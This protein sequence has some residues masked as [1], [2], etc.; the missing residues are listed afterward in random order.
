MGGLLRD[1]QEW[2]IQK[3][4]E[5]VLPA[6]Q[7]MVVVA[8]IPFRCRAP[9]A[10]DASRF[11]LGTIPPVTPPA[12]ARLVARRTPA[13]AGRP[14]RAPSVA[15]PCFVLC[16]PVPACSSSRASAP[17]HLVCTKYG[18]CEACEAGAFSQILDLYS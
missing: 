15:F 11:L 17:T 7:G 2:R 18:C 3:V 1:I 13:V 12:R 8:K 5:V 16:W 4:E 6:K 10:A 9:T 14:A